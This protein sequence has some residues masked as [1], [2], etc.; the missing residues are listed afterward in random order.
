[1]AR[2]ICRNAWP[3]YETLDVRPSKELDTHVGRTRM[4]YSGLLSHGSGRFIDKE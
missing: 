1:M 4:F 2:S 3:V